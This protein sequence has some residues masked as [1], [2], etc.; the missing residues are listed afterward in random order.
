MQARIMRLEVQLVEAEKTQLEEKPVLRGDKE[1][2]SS[3]ESLEN[4]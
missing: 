3:Q 2:S 1:E 4:P